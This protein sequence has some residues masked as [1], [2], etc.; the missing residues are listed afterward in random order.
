MTKSQTCTT[1]AGSGLDNHNELGDIQQQCFC[2]NA[3]VCVDMLLGETALSK[4]QRLYINFATNAHAHAQAH[5]R[6]GAGSVYLYTATSKKM[7][8]L[9][10]SNL[11]RR[12]DSDADL[13]VIARE[14]TEWTVLRP[15]LRIDSADEEAIKTDYKSL[16]EQRLCNMDVS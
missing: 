6:G 4:V 14:L 13:A 16:N 9:A 12:I 7:V 3:E 11:R 8:S 15:F 1:G 2:V 10:S 5:K